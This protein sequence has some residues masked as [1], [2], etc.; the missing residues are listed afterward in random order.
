MRG[1]EESED[2]EDESEEEGEER[3]PSLQS[4]LL[5]FPSSSAM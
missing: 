3:E 2:E 4:Y 5:T 1:D